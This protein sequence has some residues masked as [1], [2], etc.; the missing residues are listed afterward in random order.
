[1]AAGGLTMFLHRPE[2]DARPLAAGANMP[3]TSG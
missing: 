2:R 3:A 1:M